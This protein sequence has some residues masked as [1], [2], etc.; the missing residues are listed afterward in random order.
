[1]KFVFLL[2]VLLSG[3]VIPFTFVAPEKIPCKICGGP[4]PAPP[5]EEATMW[6]DPA[7]NETCDS[8]THWCGVQGGKADGKNLKVDADTANHGE[9]LQMLCVD[10][11][12]TPTC[13]TDWQSY[14]GTAGCRCVV[15]P[16]P[17]DG[18]DGG[19]DPSPGPLK[20]A[21]CTG[22][23]CTDDVLAHGNFDCALGEICI[24]KSASP[25][26]YGCGNRANK[27]CGEPKKPPCWVPTPTPPGP[28]DTG[29]VDPGGI[30]AQQCPTCPD[31]TPTCTLAQAQSNKQSCQANPKAEYCLEKGEAGSLTYECPG[32]TSDEP[33]KCKA[34]GTVKR[35]C[36]IK[37]TG[38][39]WEDESRAGFLSGGFTLILGAAALASFGVIHRLLYNL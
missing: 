35:P 34:D 1:M 36:K 21:K 25:P 10:K 14:Q 5:C 23:E 22:G 9:A 28:V 17:K 26:E 15:F 7:A 8:A 2:V 31:S 38:E 18:D 11:G 30:S 33:P 19:A 6:S 3:V 4:D 16:C 32:A 13:S 24:Y 37:R 27:K 29:P 39:Y 20:C 12:K